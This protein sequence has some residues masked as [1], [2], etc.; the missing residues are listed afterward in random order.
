MR[1]LSV[2]ERRGKGE[3]GVEGYHFSHDDGMPSET[4]EIWH[5]PYHRCLV[6]QMW[7]QQQ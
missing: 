3:F 1:S 7:C 5:A 2:V 4:A 6:Q